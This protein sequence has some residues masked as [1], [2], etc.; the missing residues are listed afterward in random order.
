M[1]LRDAEEVELKGVPESELKKPKI[2][3]WIM[4]EENINKKE[5]L[6]LSCPNC[7]LKIISCPNCGFKFKINS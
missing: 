1:S 2:H 6:T 4:E 3:G 5:K 7:G